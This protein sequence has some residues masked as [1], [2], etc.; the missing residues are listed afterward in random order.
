MPWFSSAVEY[1]VSRGSG[2]ISAATQWENCGAVPPCSSPSAV[3]QLFSAAVIEM[4]GRGQSLSF[5]PSF[6]PSGYVFVRKPGQE[7]KKASWF[8]EQISLHYTADRLSWR[9]QDAGN[10]AFPLHQWL[11]LSLGGIRILHFQPLG[12]FKSIRNTPVTKNQA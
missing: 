5:S 10:S 11:F 9:R 2:L 3:Y 7:T 8:L 1:F 12:K 6:S 4:C